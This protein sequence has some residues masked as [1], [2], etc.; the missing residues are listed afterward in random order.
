VRNFHEKHWENILQRGNTIHRCE[1][2]RRE[3]VAILENSSKKRFFVL[4]EIVHA[5][6]DPFDLHE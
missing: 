6:G 4:H 3:K 2:C 1:S 5:G